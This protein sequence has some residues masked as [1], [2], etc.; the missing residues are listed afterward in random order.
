MGAVSS[1]NTHNW[2]SS[3][4][5]FFFNPMRRREEKK[6]SW[7]Y[8]WLSGAN[9]SPGS[10]SLPHNAAIYFHRRGGVMD[11]AWATSLY[12]TLRVKHVSAYVQP[13]RWTINKCTLKRAHTSLIITSLFY[14]IFFSSFLN[15][16]SGFF[17]IS[18][19]GRSLNGNT[20]MLK[21]T[22]SF[23]V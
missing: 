18:Y 12:L 19:R 15:A 10:S 7:L 5:F 8:K 20:T 9:F 1:V 3:L 21:Q 13:R 17:T 16:S 2:A 4:F 23:S 22:F 14:F 11:S 6:K